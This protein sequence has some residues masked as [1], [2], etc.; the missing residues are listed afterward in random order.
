[1]ACGTEYG[2]VQLYDVRASSS[3][4]RP[5]AYT[6]DNMLSHRITSMCQMG[7]SANILAVGDTIG[8]IHLLDIRKLSAGRYVSSAR[9]S[10]K[11]GG[12]DIG[13]GRYVI[14]HRC[15]LLIAGGIYHTFIQ[16]PL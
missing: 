4:R 14:C 15:C 10:N 9:K 3:V 11:S 7:D 1:M 12:E 16:L 5:T 8:D 6:T 13:L 2:Q